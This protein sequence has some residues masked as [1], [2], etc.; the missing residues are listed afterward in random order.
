MGLEGLQ[1][2]GTTETSGDIK[3]LCAS[4][5]QVAIKACNCALF[6]PNAIRAGA[7]AAV[8]LARGN[9]TLHMMEFFLTFYSCVKPIAEVDGFGRVKIAFQITLHGRPECTGTIGACVQS[10]GGIGKR[11]GF[12]MVIDRACCG[13]QSFDG[14]TELVATHTIL[15]DVVTFIR[16]ISTDQGFILIFFVF[17]RLKYHEYG[18]R[19]DQYPCHVLF[20]ER[21][22]RFKLLLDR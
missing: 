16:T 4:A 21:I 19:T 2:F 14:T 7:M 8:A 18:H 3:L 15:A 1:F 9:G 10:N 22:I 20:H 11:A 12:G 13:K 6:R 17:T 5:P